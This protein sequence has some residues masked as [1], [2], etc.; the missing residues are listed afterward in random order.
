MVTST[1][2]KSRLRAVLSFLF[3]LLLSASAF[4]QGGKQPP[5]PDNPGKGGTIWGFEVDA[6]F[7]ATFIPSFWTP[8]T[9][10]DPDYNPVYYPNLTTF[11]TDWRALL[12]YNA[13]AHT[14]SPSTPGDLRTVGKVDGNWGN[15]AVKGEVISFSGTSNKNDDNIG[16]G[17]DPYLLE[18]GGTGPQ[19]ND[20]TNTFLHSRD[21]FDSTV[22]VY[23]VETRATNGASFLD[24]EY[25]QAGVRFD[26]LANG[27]FNLIGKGLFGGRTPGDFL[28]IV[29]YVGGHT[30]IVSARVWLSS[31]QWSDS[32]GI[33]VLRA[34]IAANVFD[35]AALDSANKSSYTDA[36]GP[37]AICKALQM[38][39][40]AVN[41]TYLQAIDTNFAKLNL[42]SPNATVTVKT[43]SS[44]SF[45]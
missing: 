44:P 3:I 34:F 12:T 19:K 13:A 25:N 23:A 39:E 22:L 38:V 21:Y 26:T 36:G 45:T 17:Q 42:C 18:L 41:L 28:L 40:G 1:V 4:G 2:T 30:P 10:Y 9:A 35:V 14:F 6:S 32:I 31:A 5:P 43:R 24:F 11:G 15:K 33:D 8:S 37:S 16:L 27:K 7:R 20:I 29:D